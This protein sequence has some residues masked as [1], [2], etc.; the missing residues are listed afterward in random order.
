MCVERTREG[1]E[2]SVKEE[3]DVGLVTRSLEFLF[4]VG[5]TRSKARTDAWA[6]G[7][8]W[9]GSFLPSDQSKR[10]PFFHISQT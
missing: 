8:A 3:E 9:A 10:L 4:L 2:V 5:E 6:L 7:W 1:C